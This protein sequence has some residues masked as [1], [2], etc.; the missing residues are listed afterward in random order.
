M[1][2]AIEVQSV[3]SSKNT[4]QWKHACVFCPYL[5]FELIEN[6][7]KIMGNEQNDHSEN[8]H[9]NPYFNHLFNILIKM[10]HISSERIF[11]F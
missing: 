1:L 9:L 8:L 6:V 7:M 3:Y 4:Q 10:F 2:N 11:Q 5:V